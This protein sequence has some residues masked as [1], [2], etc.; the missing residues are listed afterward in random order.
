M[1]KEI[2]PICNSKEFDV[3]DL[4]FNIHNLAEKYKS[5]LYIIHKD[6]AKKLDLNGGIGVLLR[7]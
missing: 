5:D 7:Y 1:E 2:C 3:D 4:R 6:L